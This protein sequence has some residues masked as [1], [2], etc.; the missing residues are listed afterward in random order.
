MK[1]LFLISIFIIIVLLISGCEKEGI[2][3]IEKLEKCDEYFVVKDN[4]LGKLTKELHSFTCMTKKTDNGIVMGG[5]CVYMKKG[6]LHNECIKAYTYNI[7]PDY[8]CLENAYLA[9]DGKCYCSYS[10]IYDENLNKCVKEKMPT[11][12]SFKKLMEESGI[13]PINNN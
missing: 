6:L 8:E 3:N 9:M 11:E 10:Y 1:K 5:E 2:V 4:W 13:K 7:K 12:R